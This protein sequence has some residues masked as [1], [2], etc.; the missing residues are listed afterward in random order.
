VG[1]EYRG[2]GSG[3]WRVTEGYFWAGTIGV[4]DDSVR[5]PASNPNYDGTLGVEVGGRDVRVKILIDRLYFG[6]L[7]RE[8]L[9]EVPR[10]R[11][12]ADEISSR[13]HQLALQF[14]ISLTT[15]FD[16]H[17]SDPSL[18]STSHKSTTW[19]RPPPNARA[20][21]TPPRTLANVKKSPN[22]N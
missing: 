22:P 21:R 16:T 11:R 13:G 2:V 8:V 15:T 19:R 10:F 6:R 20:P 18:D 14:T 5:G 17:L 12:L 3:S 4:R 7:W 9:R 1:L